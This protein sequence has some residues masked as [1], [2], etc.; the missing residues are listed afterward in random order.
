V[1]WSAA[2]GD[3]TVSR[4]ATTASAIPTTGIAS[5]CRC[6]AD[7]FAKGTLNQIVEA[8]GVDREEFLRLL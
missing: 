2:V 7:S 3:S 5:S 6:T 4:E 1:R 8:S